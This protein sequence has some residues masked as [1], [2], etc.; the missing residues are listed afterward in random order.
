MRICNDCEI[1]YEDYG[2]RTNKCRDCKNK[3]DREWHSKRSKESKEA[4]HRQ[5]MLRKAKLQQKVYDYQKGNS[6]EDCGDTRVQVLQF[7]HINPEEKED[8]ISNMVKNGISE[9]KIF[10]EIAK[11]RV[12][13]ANCHIMRTAEQLEWYKNITI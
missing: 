10:E 2:Q 6:C 9:K 4:R 8:T 3:Y 5:Q 12:L 1:E 11:C 13:C 7:D